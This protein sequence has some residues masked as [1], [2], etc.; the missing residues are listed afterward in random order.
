ML[1]EVRCLLILIGT[2]HSPLTW[3]RIRLRSPE[4]SRVTSTTNTSLLS[5]ANQRGA[6]KQRLENELQSGASG[7]QEESSRVQRFQVQGNRCPARTF[8]D[9]YQ[10]EATIRMKK[11]PLPRVIAGALATTLSIGALPYS[12]PA[13]ARANAEYVSEPSVLNA[14][15]ALQDSDVGVA[16][17]RLI[18]AVNSG[19]PIALADAVDASF[20]RSAFSRFMPRDR[21]IQMLSG[22]QEHA[23]D[24]EIVEV[25]P[26]EANEP[27]S[28]IATAKN[29]RLR[30]LIRAGSD[31]GDPKM[32]AGIGFVRLLDLPSADLAQMPTPATESEMVASIVAAIEKQAESGGFRGAI[33]LT[34]DGRTLFSRGFGEANSALSAANTVDTPFHIGSAG[35]MFTAV[36]ISQFIAEGL[37]K[38]ETTV[39]EVIPDYPSEE[40]RDNVTVEM[41]LTHQ[42]GLGTFFQ[43][44]GF[45]NG[46]TYP[47]AQSEISVYGE[48]PLFFEPGTSYRYSNAGFSLL[49]AMLERASG[50]VFSEL[51]RD[52]VLERAGM[53]H[54]Y[55]PAESE[56]MRGAAKMYAPSLTDPLGFEHL[57]PLMPDDPAVPTFAVQGFGGGYSS[58]SDMQRFFGALLD[59]TLLPRAQFEQMVAPRVEQQSGSG[60][61]YG[62][63]IMTSRLGG[64]TMI[65]HGG[66]SR[67]DVRHLMESGYTLSIATNQNPPSVT[68]TSLPIMDYV[69]RFAD[70]Q[71][72]SIDER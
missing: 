72:R 68:A 48:E 12:E 66:A 4:L 19:S 47:N 55:L 11:T 21:I 64:Q 32:L 7:H 16:L 5:K 15:A 37:L 22:I 29:G 3:P 35:K 61:F 45:V 44:P 65:G 9:L 10:S 36:L 50:V 17:L 42:A 51:V 63:G 49:A 2:Y 18:D 40:V 20:S 28:V 33:Q 24:L 1:Q 57:V 56:K 38:K 60:R 62:Y 23:P 71:S 59:G 39:G 25:R 43:S 54:T 34:K 14:S 52:R 6:A 27:L 13:W 41:L 8:L 58:V 31:R 69:A 67:F 26:K 46:A 30:V 70:S 53:S